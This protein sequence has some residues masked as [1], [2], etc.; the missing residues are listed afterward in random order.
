[1]IMNKL[2]EEI[3]SRMQPQ[4]ALIAYQNENDYFLEFREI[5]DNGRMRE[6]VPVTY[7]FMNGLVSGFSESRSGTPFGAVPAN[8]L[9]CDNRRGSERY[10]WHEPPR[11]RVM[12]F[13]K[14]LSIE[15]GEYHVPGVIYAVHGERLSIYAFK[16]KKL[17]E[18]SELYAAPFFNVS[19][20]NVCLGLAKL[21]KPSDPTFRQLLDYWEKKFWLT[22]FTHLGF[23]GNPTKNNLVLVTK[24]AKD[25][26]FDLSELVPLNLKLKDILK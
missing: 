22:E 13:Q 2:T 17:T 6:A 24:Q 10:V 26:S 5:D 16:D 21:D 20:A 23:N 19:G 9:Y 18:K 25:K 15:S 3:K 4:A 12:F 11:K 7:E 1:M 14:E 8:M